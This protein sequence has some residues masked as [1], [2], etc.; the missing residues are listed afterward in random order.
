MGTVLA[1]SLYVSQ[2]EPSPLTQKPSPVDSKKRSIQASLQRFIR[3]TGHL[4]FA[5][6]FIY[7]TAL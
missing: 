6:I 7:K 2:Q 4:V 3:L 1:D 5:E